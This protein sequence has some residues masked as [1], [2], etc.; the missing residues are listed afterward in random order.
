MRLEGQV[1]AV[2]PQPELAGW[3]E[4]NVQANRLESNVRVLCAAAG[5]HHGRATLYVPEDG[6]ELASL[7]QDW[8]RGRPH[9]RV[10]VL[11]VRLDEV[12]LRAVELV[13]IDVEQHELPA[14]RGLSGEL[15]RNRPDL[16]VELVGSERHRE[17]VASWLAGA[18]GYDAYYIAEDL[19]R[20]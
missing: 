6:T 8:V 7:H 5:D 18:Y 9:A 10:E 12:V 14:L 2:E 17:E 20:V 16:L 1:I 11:L 15:E 3:I 13:K 4:R 19:R